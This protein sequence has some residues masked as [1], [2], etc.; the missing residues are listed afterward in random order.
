MYLTYAEATPEL[1]DQLPAYDP[2]KIEKIFS[3]D[4]SGYLGYVR[5]LVRFL[6]VHFSKILKNI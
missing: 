2:A 4:L 5:R 6:K 3:P 1:R